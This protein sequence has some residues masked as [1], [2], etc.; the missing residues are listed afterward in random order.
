MRANQLPRVVSGR[1]HGQGGH[2]PYPDRLLAEDEEVV[3]R[4]HPHW[5]MLVLPVLIFILLAGATSFVAAQFDTPGARY[6]VIAVAALLVIIFTVRPFLRWRTTH[7]VVTTHRV[8][9]R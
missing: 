3:L 5:K 6:G 4:L 2:L 8:L 1:S 9:I 7:F